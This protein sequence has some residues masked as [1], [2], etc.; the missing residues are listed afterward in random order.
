MLSSSF[1]HNNF[2]AIFMTDFR[3]SYAVFSYN[4]SD[5]NWGDHAII[6]YKASDEDFE[7]HPLS[8][9]NA[10]LVDCLQGN[11]TD[12]FYNLNPSTF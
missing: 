1:Q 2:T 11:S 10:T 4:C 6:G 5:I 7:E 9:H 12:V 8:G 3:Q